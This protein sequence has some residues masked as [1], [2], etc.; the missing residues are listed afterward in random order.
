MYLKNNLNSSFSRC[1]KELAYAGG[2]SGR[3]ALN[4][5]LPQIPAL[6]AQPNGVFYLIAL[7]AND[8]PQLCEALSSARIRGVVCARRRAGIEL[9]YVVK[10]T[11]LQQE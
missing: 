2:P 11:W 3:D 6:L 1:S 5:L 9:L 8:V 10:F 4:R 7:D